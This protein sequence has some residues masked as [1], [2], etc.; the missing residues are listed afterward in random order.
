[1]QIPPLLLTLFFLH[2]F[3]RALSSDGRVIDGATKQVILLALPPANKCA[4][5]T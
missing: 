2:K 5:P 4:H 1:M 3:A